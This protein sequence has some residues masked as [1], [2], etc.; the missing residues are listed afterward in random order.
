M[1]C[2][3]K[4]ELTFCIK[5]NI[6]ACA[7]IDIALDGIDQEFLRQRNFTTVPTYEFLAIPEHK[8]LILEIKK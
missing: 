3:K 1:M 8:D 5:P 6:I 7:S 4:M 2:F